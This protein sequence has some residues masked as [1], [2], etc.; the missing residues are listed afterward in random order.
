MDA[1][2]ATW[3]GLLMGGAGATIGYLLG[4]RAARPSMRHGSSRTDA[5]TPHLLPDPALAWLRRASGAMGVWAVE[6]TGPGLGHRTYQSLDPEWSGGVEVLEFIEHRLA[7][8]ANREGDAVERLDAGLLLTSSAGGAVVAA[9]LPADASGP[10]QTAVRTDLAALLDGVG[11]R[12]VLHEL[13]QVQEGMAIETVESVGMR[14][15]Y[16]IERIAGAEAYVA[17]SE[18]SG[19]RVIG[20]SGL[21]DRRTLGQIVPADAALARVAIG[22]EAEA[23]SAD[24]L[25]GPGADRRRHPPARVAP[26]LQHDVAIGG[27]AWRVPDGGLVGLE[28]IREVG[29]ALR[30]AAP[31]LEMAARLAAETAKAIKDPL[32]G[33]LNRRGLAERM[34]LIGPERGALISLDLD[35]FKRLNDTLG[36]AAGD[37]ALLHLA[38]ILQEQVRGV[39]SAARVGGEEF[40]L[41]LP[42]TSLE[43]G[44]RVAERIRVRIGTTGWDWQGHSWPLSA[45]FGV[46]AWPET[47]R[48]RENLAA[49]ADAALYAAK[50]GGRDRVVTWT[51]ALQ[52]RC[53][54]GEELKQWV[55]WPGREGHLLLERFRVPLSWRFT[56][57]FAVE[58][59]HARP[60]PVLLPPSHRLP[61][62]RR[63]H[64]LLKGRPVDPGFDVG[65]PDADRCGRRRDV[66]HDG[67]GHG[68]RRRQPEAHA[69]IAGREEDDLQ[70]HPGHG[71]LR[72]GPGG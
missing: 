1:V 30:A 12:P 70:G 62:L 54:Q 32:T 37:A 31:R 34:G 48:S 9:L 24:P 50:R 55:G 43:E 35:R 13:S 36:H 64:S 28:T 40:L 5:A 22:A 49:Q 27:I 42:G 11:R 10:R 3:L 47:T 20:V 58:D 6:S 63:G 69:A 67:H 19:V 18:A 60:P 53:R 15:A 14:L 59:P 66:L 26:L 38:R 65:D 61:G 41:W 72:E 2:T 45:S 21:A 68:H 57:S 39:D 33:L 4:R 51:A 17:V 52:G 29:E 7:A 8:A 56:Q 71:E 25:G 44:V 16:Q 46:A 23:T